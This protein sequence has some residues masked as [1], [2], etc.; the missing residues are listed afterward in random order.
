MMIGNMFATLDEAARVVYEPASCNP[1]IDATGLVAVRQSDGSI[2]FL[3]PE[4]VDSSVLVPDYIVW[5]P[6]VGYFGDTPR[7]VTE[8]LIDEVTIEEIEA[9]DEAIAQFEMDAAGQEVLGTLTERISGRPLAL[10]VDGVP[11]RDRNGQVAASVISARLEEIFPV[12]GLT[13]E[14]AARLAAIINGKDED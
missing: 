13:E 1:V 7:L 14:D 10:F 12:F 9:L 6:A 2:R 3:E 11:L 4:P 8:A 5:V